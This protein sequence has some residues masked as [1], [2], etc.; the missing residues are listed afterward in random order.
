MHVERKCRAPSSP[1]CMEVESSL[2]GMH[3]SYDIACKASG[4]LSE[5]CSP[6][7]YYIPLSE[8]YTLLGPREPV[9]DTLNIGNG[10]LG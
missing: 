8:G 3:A 7:T 2:Y 9:V 5:M 10:A 6:S 1:E 4:L